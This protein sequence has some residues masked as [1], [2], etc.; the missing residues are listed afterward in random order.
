MGGRWLRR[1]EVVT[2]LLVVGVSCSGG[3]FNV[4]RHWAVS[5]GR[6]L[7]IR[8]PGDVRGTTAPL[9]REVVHALSTARI[10]GTG[11]PL[12]ADPFRL[13][14]LTDDGGLHRLDVAAAAWRP[15]NDQ[16]AIMKQLGGRAGEPLLD[17]GGTSC[18]GPMYG[19]SNMT[20]R[21]SLLTLQGCTMLDE[22]PVPGTAKIV[23]VDVANKM[24]L[25]ETGERFMWTARGWIGLGNLMDSSGTG[26]FKCVEGFC[27]AIGDLEPGQVVEMPESVARE[28]VA[29]G[30]LEAV[31]HEQ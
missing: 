12:A 4:Q 10:P 11:R 28:H 26:R 15:G 1:G 2:A 22:S 30:R 23:A 18:G 21:V 31:S 6:L 19:V 5:P 29:S 14:V 9:R 8:D 3:T 16:E 7:L 24:A 13:V 25:L 17:I 27:S 20:R